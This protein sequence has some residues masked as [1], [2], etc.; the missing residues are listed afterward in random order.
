MEGGGVSLM[1]PWKTYAFS[2]T[3]L[4]FRALIVTYPVVEKRVQ[5]RVYYGM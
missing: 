2:L 1:D 3:F 4:S 5:E